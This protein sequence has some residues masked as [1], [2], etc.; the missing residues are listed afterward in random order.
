MIDTIAKPARDLQGVDNDIL[1]Y[2]CSGD[3]S[4]P[5]QDLPRALKDLT[6]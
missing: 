4:T 1:R 6:S 5:V 3:T 2:T